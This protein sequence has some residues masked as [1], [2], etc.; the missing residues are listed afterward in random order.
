MKR[1]LAIGGF[2]VLLALLLLAS[3][4]WWQ[5]GA[6][7]LT[8]QPIPHEVQ[9]LIRDLKSVN[10]EVRLQALNALADKGP[11]AEPAVPALIELF[12]SYDEDDRL[13]AALALGKIG[14]SAVDSLTT[15]LSSS[16]ADVRYYGVWT[17]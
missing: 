13:N 2:I 10:P 12:H 5:G 1:P 7:L 4:W 17:L 3:V 11:E 14:P 8:V 16:D 6:R 9:G 15:A